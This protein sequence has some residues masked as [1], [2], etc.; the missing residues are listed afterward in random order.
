MRGVKFAICI[1][2]IKQN[3]EEIKTVVDILKKDTDEVFVIFNNNSG[4]HAAQNAKAI[5]KETRY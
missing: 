3:L 1:I 5:S 4:K 2:I